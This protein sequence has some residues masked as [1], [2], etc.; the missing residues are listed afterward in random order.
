[1]NNQPLWGTQGGGTVTTH[2]SG[3][4]VF[5]DPPNWGGFAPGDV[6]P[7][8]WGIVAINDEANRIDDPIDEWMD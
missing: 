2:G 7:D 1:M 4:Y 6:M 3:V 8:E 5:V